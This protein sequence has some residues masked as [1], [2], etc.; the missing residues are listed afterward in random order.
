[1][2]QARDTAEILSSEMPGE[3]ALP[4]SERGEGAE[5]ELHPD[6]REQ[7]GFQTGEIFAAARQITLQLDTTADELRRIC[8]D[9]DPFFVRVGR[10]LQMVA[11]ET[12]QLTRTIQQAGDA[13][14][15]REEGKGPL[16]IT[17]QL[18][19]VIQSRLAEDK[20]A[21]NVNLEQIRDLLERISDCRRIN[22]SIDRISS[23]F[24][25]VRIN[26]RIQ[27]SVQLL[28]EDIFKDVTDDIDS[29]SETLITIT[30][31]IKKDLAAATK[32][33][34]MLER[35]VTRNLVDIERIS[36]QARTIIGKTYD[37]I[38]QL[39]TAATQMMGKADTGSQTV[40]QKIDDVVVAIQFHDSLSQRSD[41]II[42]AFNDVR[43]LCAADAEE[44]QPQHLGTAYHILDLQHRQ[45]KHIIE[46]IS[47]VH[48]RIKKSFKDMGIEVEGLNAI[49][50]DS[51]FQA[52]GPQQFLSTLYSSL[53][54][55]MYDL[56]N[57]LSSGGSLLKQINDAALDT[58]RVAQR[59]MNIMG[60]INNMRDETRLQAVNT[61]I[62]ASNLGQKGRTIQVLAKEIS[63]L[64]DQTSVLVDDVEALQLS[65]KQKV[66]ELCQTFQEGLENTSTQALEE[67]IDSI[68]D[69]YKD[70]EGLIVSVSDQI[71]TTCT[72]VHETDRSL[73]FLHD[74]R[75]R[76][77]AVAKQVDAAR[78][79]LAPWQD[80]VS[81]ESEEMN[82]L[83]ERY[84]MEQERMIHMFDRA[85][86]NESYQT[87]EDIFF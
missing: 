79:R 8:T 69:S 52:I 60:D 26:I 2:T 37:N 12:K 74:L 58:E 32:K 28:S 14:S 41:H 9:T 72:H 84:T 75:L 39:L 3:E 16:E 25:A 10:D 49:F 47:S 70:I 57:L 42:H 78:E 73:S 68:G 54:K 27:C 48:E 29:L 7:T 11:D 36:L 22:D 23:S 30:K 40:A 85:E 31:Q 66:D 71:E 87:D 46:E 51:Q 80:E 1:M 65:V 6:A 56:C 15:S 50:F 44:L 55:G 53:Q 59:L 81:R 67:Q 5:T 33:L 64:S 24:R 82:Q 4:E 63:S 86:D 18:I 83:L 34:G 13:V 35:T 43:S 76:L 17:E 62:M 19:R 61:I 77:K 38:R 20:E 45:L 21:I